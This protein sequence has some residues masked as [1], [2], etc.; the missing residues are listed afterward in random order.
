MLILLLPADKPGRSVQL[1]SGRCRVSGPGRGALGIPGDVVEIKDGAARRLI[2]LGY[3]EEHAAEVDLP[4]P[5]ELPA[6]LPYI[7][8]LADHLEGKPA[9][10]ILAMSMADGRS[11]AADIYAEA[12]S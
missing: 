12:L 3:A 10:Y 2:E 11:T 5:V 1:P 8:D 7:T 6:R 4:E 9:D